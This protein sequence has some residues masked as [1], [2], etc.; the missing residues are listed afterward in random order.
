MEHP[1]C[2]FDASK[3]VIERCSPSVASF[4]NLLLGHLHWNSLRYARGKGL[5]VALSQRL[6]Y[7]RTSQQRCAPANCA[8]LE[9][10]S[11]SAASPSTCS[12]LYWK[13]PGRWSLA[14]NC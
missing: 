2:A 3:G 8:A 5:A 6:E 4:H 1:D 12:S 9:S 14:R 11:S 7:Q 10:G 13:N